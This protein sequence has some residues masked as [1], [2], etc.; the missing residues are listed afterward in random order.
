MGILARNFTS[1]SNRPSRQFF[2]LFN[3]LIDLKAHRDDLLGD[4]ADDSSAI[5]NPEE[6]LNQI[7]DKIKAQQRLKQEAA[8]ND[9]ADDGDELQAIEVAKEQEKLLCG[10]ITLTGKIIAK[11]DAAVSDRI[12]QEKDLIGQ[13]FKEFLFASYYQAQA[14]GSHGEAIIIQQQVGS[15][16]D[17]KKTSAPN[18][19]SREA[20]YELL[21]MMIK[22][23]TTLMKGF[24]EAQL[25]PLI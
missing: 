19:K 11:A 1:I 6:L 18:N 13:I 9:A 24:L 20:A 5:Y 16:T 15:R 25:V 2:E 7:I 22:N 8:S 21:H 3:K 17:K 12:I 23:S 14:E 10:L 4:A